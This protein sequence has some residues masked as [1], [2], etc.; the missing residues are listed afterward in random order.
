MNIR[1]TFLVVCAASVLFLGLLAGCFNV[2]SPLDHPSGDIQLISAARACFDRGDLQC[3]MDN[4]QK[5]SPNSLEI[6][7]SEEAFVTLDQNGAGM[8][9]FMQSFGN[10]GGGG[11][12]TKLAELMGQGSLA[13]RLSILGAFKNLASITT[14]APL[15]G[16]VRF[17]LGIGLAA[18]VLSEELVSSATLSKTLLSNTST[19]CS[20]F[21]AGTCAAC[22]KPTGSVIQ[23]TGVTSGEL[24]TDPTAATEYGTA[25]P[26]LDMLN[27]ALSQANFALGA[28]ELGAS[29]KFSGTSGTFGT[30]LNTGPRGAGGAPCFRSA[31]ISNG[32][33]E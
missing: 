27:G 32:V 25:N 14:N 28:T 13:K 30:I 33:G 7:M 24:P 17:S 22:T 1:Y 21:N 3:A 23:D 9:S 6:Q 16:L 20:T 15:R 18:E 29:G 10:G 26:D 4:Y 8:S 19:A 11:S 31:L 12:L 2:F 5:L